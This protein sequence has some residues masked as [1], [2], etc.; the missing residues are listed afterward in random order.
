LESS[1]PVG[2]LL[3]QA[4]QKPDYQ[5]VGAPGWINTERY[6]IRATVP[7][8]TPPAAMSVMMLN[9]LKIGSNWQRISKPAS[10]RSLIS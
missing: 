8:G 3:R 9:L 1:A 10:R 2:L 6:S 4:L 5:M 7:A